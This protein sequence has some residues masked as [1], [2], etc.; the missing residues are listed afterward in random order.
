MD[1][2]PWITQIRRCTDQTRVLATRLV[3]RTTQGARQTKWFITETQTRA[4][5]TSVCPD[6]RWDKT[7]VCSDSARKQTGWFQPSPC[8]TY[9]NCRSNL[10]ADPLRTS[11]LLNVKLFSVRWKTGASKLCDPKKPTLVGLGLG[12]R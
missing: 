6:R 12:W 3:E 5:R 2:R 4:C 1:P 10:V 8:C 7:H 11:G 9:I